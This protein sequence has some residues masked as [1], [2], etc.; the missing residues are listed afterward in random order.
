M[1]TVSTHGQ[2][3]TRPCVVVIAVLGHAFF[4]LCLQTRR[5]GGLQGGSL[6]GRLLRLGRELQYG[7]DQFV[8]MALMMCL[9]S[10]HEVIYDSFIIYENLQ[11]ARL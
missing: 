5:T 9:D 7:N 10:K 11:T 4:L 6:L 8:L 2:L 1:D 3:N